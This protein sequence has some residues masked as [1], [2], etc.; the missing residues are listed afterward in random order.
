MDSEI[1]QALFSDLRLRAG[2]EGCVQ[3]MT[4]KTEIPEQE[5]F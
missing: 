1:P 3:M 2:V 4:A 5:E